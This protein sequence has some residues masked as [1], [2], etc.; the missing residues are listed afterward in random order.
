MVARL[1][2]VQPFLPVASRGTRGPGPKIVPS[3]MTPVWGSS[4]YL[5]GRMRLCRIQAPVEACTMQ[6]G[7]PVSYRDCAPRCPSKFLQNRGTRQN[8]PGLSL[9]DIALDKLHLLG[10]ISAS[11]Y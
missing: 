11:Y 8:Y 4:G 2:L 3:F 10:F 5:G 1:S 6:I 7:G 9:Y